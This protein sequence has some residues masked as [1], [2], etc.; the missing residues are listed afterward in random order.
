MGEKTCK[1]GR[2]G[3]EKAGAKKTKR[4]WAYSQV[5]DVLNQLGST[6]AVMSWVTGNE[7]KAGK[8]LLRITVGWAEGGEG[9]EGEGVK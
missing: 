5:L 4:G 3:N 1:E 6:T 8:L 2:E 9:G 7:G